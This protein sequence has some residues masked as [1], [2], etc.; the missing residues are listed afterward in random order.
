M[1]SLAV[2]GGVIIVLGLVYVGGRKLLSGR[3]D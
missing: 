3:K 1:A 2:V